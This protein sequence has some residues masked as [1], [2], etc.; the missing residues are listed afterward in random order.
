MM[1]LETLAKCTGCD[2]LN[3]D[4]CSVYEAP[5]KQW[6]RIGGCAAKTRQAAVDRDQ[7]KKV[8]PLKASKRTRE[9]KK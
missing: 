4:A 1:D 9:I 3:F 7:Q 8:N 5:E 2:H 6:T